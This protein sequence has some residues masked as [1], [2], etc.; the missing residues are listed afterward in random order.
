MT[1][2]LAIGATDGLL[3][4]AD[5][6]RVRP[7]DD[8]DR[9]EVIADD[10]RKMLG[11]PRIP[12]IVLTS[13][14]ATYNGVHISEVLLAEGGPTRLNRCSSLAS[15]A[16]YCS[17]VLSAKHTAFP[18]AH[19]AALLLVGLAGTAGPTAFRIDVPPRDFGDAAGL[20]TVRS[21]PTNPLLPVLAN[22]AESE[23]AALILGQFDLFVDFLD[24]LI[25]HPPAPEESYRFR[26]LPLAE[27]RPAVINFLGTWFSRN[28]SLASSD[29]VGGLWSVAEVRVDGTVHVEYGVDLFPKSDQIGLDAAAQPD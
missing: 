17:D 11:L 10:D 28:R 19:D 16:E 26:G 23:T 5:G 14:R 6:L 2:T 13:G 8:P 1:L 25:S 9:P 20:T 24:E 4:L 3:A 21:V 7:T 18:S 22:P 12:A 27:L 29:G 15:A